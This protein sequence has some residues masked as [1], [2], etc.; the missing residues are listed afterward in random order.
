M[1][2]YRPDIVQEIINKMLVRAEEIIWN[3]PGR[4]KREKFYRWT[5]KDSRESKGINF[6]S[7][8]HRGEAKFQRKKSL[9]NL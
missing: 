5:L 6:P 8:K 9:K 4:I 1:V 2:W 7:G 3:L